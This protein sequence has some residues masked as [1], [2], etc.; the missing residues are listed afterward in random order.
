[1][2]RGAVGEHKTGEDQTNLLAEV[3]SQLRQE[4]PGGIAVWGQ[5]PS[6][7]KEPHV[8]RQRQETVLAWGTVGGSVWP[9]HR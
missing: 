3:T 7:Q 1:M 5:G 8:H 6:R 9:D 2:H 4:G